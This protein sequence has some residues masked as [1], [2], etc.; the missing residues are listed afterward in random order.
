MGHL[1]QLQGKIACFWFSFQKN[2]ARLQGKLG[3]EHW[4]GCN[5]I[6]FIMKEGVGEHSLRINSLEFLEMTLM[7][8]SEERPRLES[9]GTGRPSV[10]Q[11]SCNTSSY[12]PW[13][14][15]PRNIAELPFSQSK[16]GYFQVQHCKRAFWLKWQPVTE[17][18]ELTVMDWPGCISLRSFLL[19][20]LTDFLWCLPDCSI[21][22]LW[23][24]VSRAFPAS[25]AAV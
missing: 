4:F 13:M 1:G 8:G 9:Q 20:F 3:V 21:P 15:W 6:L 16:R 14:C 24:A 2:V 25:A 22:G 19:F 11:G 17:S 23:F 18:A 12:L 7:H 5:Q 10:S